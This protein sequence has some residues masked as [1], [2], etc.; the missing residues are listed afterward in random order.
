MET[1]KQFSQ[2]QDLKKYRFVK[3]GGNVIPEPERFSE[4]KYLIESQEDLYPGI[5]MWLKKRVKPEIKSG[6]RFGILVYH[7]EDPVGAAIIRKGEQA[8]L[9]SMRI[10][11]AHQDSSIGS[12][13]MVLIGL[14]LRHDAKAVHFTIPDN[15]WS[16]H[17]SF[18]EKYGFICQGN[19]DKQYRLFSN[20]LSCSA[21]YRNIW[22]QIVISLNTISD[23]VLKSELKKPKLIL[24]IHNQYL[25]KIFKG[26]KKIEIRT[27]F[28]NKWKGSKVVF[29]SPLPYQEFVGEAVVSDIEENTPSEIW[30]SYYDQIDC[31]REEFQGYCGNNLKVKALKLS[32][33]EKYSRIVPKS[34]IEN[35]LDFEIHSPQSYGVIENNQDL[36]KVMS[37]SGILRNF[38]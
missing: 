9:C 37:L 19:C 30:E 1:P 3:F 24:S 14:E 18:F 5:D 6:K 15:I 38:R 21:N 36:K 26:E 11:E 27:K 35:L 4:L 17:D 8:K 22:N 29:Y 28:S 10:D 16:R 7:G 31:T 2:N 13:L 32:E 25:D 33:V 34:Q 20:E 23:F 12:L